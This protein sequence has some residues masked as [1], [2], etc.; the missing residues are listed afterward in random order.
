MPKAER[1]VVGAFACEGVQ[2]TPIKRRD[3]GADRAV[4]KAEVVIVALRVERVNLPYPGA[5]RGRIEK[6]GLVAVRRPRNEGA[7]L[8]C[9]YLP[10]I[11]GCNIGLRPHIIAGRSDGDSDKFSVRRKI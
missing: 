11:Y 3:I 5:I 1:R 4:R 2:N 8:S 10:A 6:Q 7:H 9:C